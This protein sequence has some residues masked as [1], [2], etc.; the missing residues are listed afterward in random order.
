MKLGK[1]RTELGQ[2]SPNTSKLLA[3]ML[4]LDLSHIK[5]RKEKYFK[6]SSMSVLCD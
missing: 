1:F 5:A 3:P 6:V 4:K 2:I